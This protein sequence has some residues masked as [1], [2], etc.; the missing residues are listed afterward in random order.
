MRAPAPDPIRH[1]IRF[2]AAVASAFSNASPE[3]SCDRPNLHQRISLAAIAV[4]H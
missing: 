1:R 4:A 3:R 2:L